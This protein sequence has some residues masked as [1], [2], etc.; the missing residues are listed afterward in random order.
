V[1]NPPK[2]L[3]ASVA[4]DTKDADALGAD[5]VLYRF[6]VDSLTEYAVFAVSPTGIVISW[7][8]GAEKTFGYAQAEIVGKS[9]DVI[10]T[11]EDKASGAPQNE[12]ASAL[13]GE[14]TQHDRWHVRKDST[15]FWGTNTVQ[16][17]YDSA[18]V[19]LGFTKLVRDSTKSHLALEE[20]SDSE[21]QL[22]LLI[23]SVNDYAIFSL[24]LDGTIKNWNSG[25]QNV[26]GYAQSEIIGSNFAALFS[27]DDIAAGIPQAELRRATTHGFTDVERWLLRKDGSRF[28]ASGKLSQLKRDAAGELRGFVKIAHDITHHHAAA[29]DLRHQAH[30]DELT[31]LPNRRAFYAH[32]QQAIA[33]MKRRP[34]NL[35]AVLFIDIDHF[36]S[37]NDEHGHI[38]AD[39]LLAVTARRLERCVRSIDVV[40]RLGGDEFAILLMAITD[41]AAATEAADRV[42]AE[43]AQ[44]VI[45]DKQAVR[46]TASI[47]IA[48][49]SETHGLPEDILRDADAAMYV[50]KT[51]GRAQSVVFDG[52]MATGDRANFD[53]AEDVHKAIAE[54]ELRLAYQPILRL[55][56]ATVVGFEALVRWQHPRR[57]LL[58]PAQFIPKA[59]ES[60]LIVS[61]DRWVLGE[62]CR[63]LAQWKAQGIGK[64]LQISVNIS[65][66]EFSRVD[67]LGELHELL[68]SNGVAPARLRL[69]ITES[70]IMERS[71]RAEALLTA[72]RA[73]GVE[74]D[75]DDFGTGYASLAALGHLA[76][77][78]LKIDSTFVARM[79]SESGTHLVETVMLL[80][81]KFRIAVIAEG[82]ETTGQLEQLRALGCDFGQGFLFAPPL[83]ATQA[84]Q[85]AAQEQHL[86]A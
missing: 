55:D 16:P 13:S 14:Q 75:V 84:S 69:E 78:A 37:V 30:Y 34:A 18:G 43:M 54:H 57:G 64:L 21:Q 7:N 25:G 56:N 20:L 38:I 24:E 60:Q 1:K 45:I 33:L 26:F 53:F 29:Q 48:V 70:A 39:Q 2:T 50:A 19:L 3:A 15:R 8:S 79:D 74:V 80:A 28:L 58:P 77:D 67:F 36:K 85:F 68:A 23:E 49:G 6:L 81:R 10:F 52:T 62:A 32:V 44:P 66:K 72:I 76:V 61:I 42:A 17:L 31:E 35:F 47:G 65:S 27:A 86:T 83:D 71:S 9:F 5:Q 22:R 51:A 40:A 41:A 46:A 12:L 73:L 59:E 11:A 82:I 4:G 63:Q